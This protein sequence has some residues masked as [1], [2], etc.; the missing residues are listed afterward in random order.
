MDAPPF[1]GAILRPAGS[2]R[3]CRGLAYVHAVGRRRRARSLGAL[4]CRTARTASV[5]RDSLHGVECAPAGQR[6]GAACSRSGHTPTGN[7]FAGSR[8]ETLQS[9]ARHV[10]DAGRAKAPQTVPQTPDMTGITAH[11]KRCTNASPAGTA[12]SRPGVTGVRTQPSVPGGRSVRTTAPPE[13]PGNFCC[14]IWPA[15]RRTAGARMGWPGSA[16]T[17]RSWSSRSF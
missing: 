12:N 14:T 4:D 5:Q 10:N 11:L 13:M 9:Q 17:I 16:T 15:A 1:S 7:G 2:P 3:T 8:C 6:H